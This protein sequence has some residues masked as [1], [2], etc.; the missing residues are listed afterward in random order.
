MRA[1]K[2]WRSICCISAIVFA[3]GAAL[4]FGPHWT[5][6]RMRS[7]IEAGDAASF[8]SHVDFPALKE[9]FKAQLITKMSEILKSPDKRDPLAG[10]GQLLAMG[11]INQM[12]DTLVS[13]AG[14]MFMLQEGRPKIGKG[15]PPAPGTTPQQVEAK[16]AP[17]FEIHYVDWSTAEIR[18]KDGTPGKFLLKRDGFFAWRLSGVEIPM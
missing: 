7:A 11:V 15:P 12:V 2:S 10:F 6:Y 5:V 8:S 16:R 13:P 14:V 1:M 18:F 9:S 3:I 17:K 4:Y